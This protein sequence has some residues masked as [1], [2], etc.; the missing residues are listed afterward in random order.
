MG[1][2]YGGYLSLVTIVIC[3]CIGG[4]LWVQMYNPNLDIIQHKMK[5]NPMNVVE[6]KF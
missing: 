4:Y 1:S 6:G 3:L 5:P 2:K